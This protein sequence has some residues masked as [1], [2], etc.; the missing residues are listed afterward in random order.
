MS[1]DKSR[2][3]KHKLDKHGIPRLVDDK[4][5]YRGLGYLAAKELHAVVSRTGLSIQNLQK[6][7]RKYQNRNKHKLKD[8][9]K[10]VLD[11]TGKRGID[12]SAW[13]AF[14]AEEGVL[15]LERSRFEAGIV[16]VYD[17]KTLRL[18]D[19]MVPDLLHVE[20]MD[21]A[22]DP[23]PV[24]NERAEYCPPMTLKQIA[25]RFGV[26]TNTMRKWL[27]KKQVRGKKLGRFWS[28]LKEDMLG[29]DVNLR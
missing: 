9:V 19:R 4:G 29:N 8:A 1:R 25:E 3:L 24:S 20:W 17:Q 23:N 6:I 28:V 5:F 22:K 14:R 11:P 15:F 18:L 16:L 27:R 13:I 26:H 10:L 21:D 2:S 7:Y 12:P